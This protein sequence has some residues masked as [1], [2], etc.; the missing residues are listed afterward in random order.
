[1]AEGPSA[2]PHVEESVAALAELHVAH[3]REAPAEQRFV[4]AA[5]AMIARPRT[6]AVLAGAVAAWL[7]LNIGL[8]ASGRAAPDPYPFSL[9]SAMVSTVALFVT[10]MVLI[11]QRHDDELATRREQLTLEVA[12]LT[13]QKSAKIIALLEEFRRAD[14]NQSNRRDRVAVAL[15]EPADPQVVLDAIRGRAR[16]A[17]HEGRCGG[18]RER[19]VRGSA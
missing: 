18:G 6:L 2:P 11:A 12:I 8:E 17:G 5:T 4:T 7:V 13:E 19:V 1:M 3:Y 14:P 16:G 15:A 10:T 9:L